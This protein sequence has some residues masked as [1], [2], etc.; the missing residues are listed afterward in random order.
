MKKQKVGMRV[1]GIVLLVKNSRFKPDSITMQTVQAF[2]HSL[3]SRHQVV[4][5]LFEFVD[6]AF[7]RVVCGL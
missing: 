1:Y 7:F 6:A 3:H 5:A 2:L 4:D